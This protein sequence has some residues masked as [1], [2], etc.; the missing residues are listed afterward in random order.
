MPHRLFTFHLV[1]GKETKKQQ[2]VAIN[3]EDAMLQ[4]SISL[5]DWEIDVMT[6]LYSKYS[7]PN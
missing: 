6:C 4:L 7:P 3:E 1:Q 2:I 5:P